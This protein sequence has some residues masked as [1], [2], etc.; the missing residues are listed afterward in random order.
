M[1]KDKEQKKRKVE[2]SSE[3]ESSS[4][5][6]EKVTKKAKSGSKGEVLE[7]DLSVSPIASP[8][9]GSKLQEKIFSVIKKVDEEKNVFRGVKET[10]KAIRK[11]AKGFVVLAANVSPLDV[12]SHVPVLCEDNS[13]PYVFVSRKEELGSAGFSKSNRSASMMLIKRKDGSK[14]NAKVDEIL[15]EIKNLPRKE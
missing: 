5:E 10:M 8:L 2:E 4:S 12:F 3:S 11:G 9:A 6:E 15:A 14:L 13:I 1:A 7:V